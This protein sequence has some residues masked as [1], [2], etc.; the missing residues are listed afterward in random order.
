MLQDGLLAARAHAVRAVL[1]RSLKASLL[2]RDAN[3]TAGGL[4]SPMRLYQ[5]WQ[6]ERDEIL[7]HQWLESEKAGRDI[8]LGS[9]LVEWVLHHHADWRKGRAQNR[10]AGL[11]AALVGADA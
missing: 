1:H 3:A 2:G 5:E 8:G 4:A 6:A 10:A 11:V 7:R 9:A